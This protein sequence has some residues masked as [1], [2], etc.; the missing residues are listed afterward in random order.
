MCCSVGSRSPA[1]FCFLFDWG[2][3]LDLVHGHRY[4]PSLLGTALPSTTIVGRPLQ[5]GTS[6]KRK[7]S[8]A[9]LAGCEVNTSTLHVRGANSLPSVVMKEQVL[10]VLRHALHGQWAVLVK[11]QCV[12]HTV[13]KAQGCHAAVRM[14]R[15]WCLRDRRWWLLSSGCRGC[16]VRNL[17][18]K[19]RP[20]PTHGPRFKPY[21]REMPLLAT[22]MTSVRFRVFADLWRRGFRITSAFKFGGDF[23]AYADDPMF[24]HAQVLIL[25]AAPDLV[26]TPR[27]LIQV[28]CFCFDLDTSQPR[29]RNMCARLRRS[30]LMPT[31]GNSWQRHKQGCNDCGFASSGG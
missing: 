16:A 25:V 15:R 9:G 4:A 14:D 19:I 6:R 1:F 26:V 12:Q 7:R 10:F 3:V 8:K 22:A 18:W 20:K 11:A 21:F 23:L 13:A 24:C 31:G 29:G 5:W 17:P 30:T 27:M 2:S 28:F